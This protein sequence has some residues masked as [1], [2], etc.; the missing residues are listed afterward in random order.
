MKDNLFTN[1]DRLSLAIWLISNEMNQG[2]LAN[3]LN[4]SEAYI[5]LVING[6]RPV[7]E[8]LKKKFKEIGY[9]F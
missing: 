1:K 3:K 8:D 4:L 6:K 2:D 7:T 9:E 5:S